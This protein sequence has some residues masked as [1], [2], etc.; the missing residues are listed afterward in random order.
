LLL[1][2]LAA[3][4]ERGVWPR[5]EPWRDSLQH[6]ATVAAARD[7]RAELG[8]ALCF[9]RWRT[10]AARL[11]LRGAADRRCEPV[12]GFVRG[13]WPVGAGVGA[14]GASGVRRRL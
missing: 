8:V 14:A 12:A 11:A 1:E 5:R 13:L 3:V 4:A 10:P 2:A 7:H 6:L 9:Q